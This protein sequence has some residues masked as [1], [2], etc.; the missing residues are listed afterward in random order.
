MMCSSSPLLHLPTELIRLISTSTDADTF[1][2]LMLTCR[3]VHNSSSALIAQHNKYRRLFRN[4]LICAPWEDCSR[5]VQDLADYAL[6]IAAHPEIAQYVHSL[7]VD[8]NREPEDLDEPDPAFEDEGLAWIRAQAKGRTRADGARLVADLELASPWFQAAAA[9]SEARIEDVPQFRKLYYGGD[10][11]DDDDDDDD[12]ETPIPE[13]EEEDAE[14]IIHHLLVLLLSRL[15][16]IAILTVG[17]SNIELMAVPYRDTTNRDSH[18]VLQ[19]MTTRINDEEGYQ[20]KRDHAEHPVCQLEDKG[21]ACP[22]SEKDKARL[23]ACSHLVSPLNN[24]REVRLD[25]EHSTECMADAQVL[26][27]AWASPRVKSMFASCLVASGE[28]DGDPAPLASVVWRETHPYSGIERLELAA[29]AI[30]P[31]AIGQLLSRM[32]FLKTLRYS[33]MVKEVLIGHDWDVDGFLKTVARAC[34]RVPALVPED[35]PGKQVDSDGVLSSRSNSQTQ[36]LG[37]Q[38][39]DLGIAVDHMSNTYPTGV[40]S[41]HEFTAL[42]RLEVDADI[43]FGPNP[44]SG[45]RRSGKSPSPPTQPGFEK[46][47]RTKDGHLP[48]LVDVLPPS[49]EELDLHVKGTFGMEWVNLLQGFGAERAFKLPLL[50]K[51]TVHGELVHVVGQ[52]LSD[53]AERERLATLAR[54]AIEEAGADHMGFT[55]NFQ[56]WQDEFDSRV[57]AH[58]TLVGSKKE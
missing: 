54:L 26:D 41:L 33:H 49:I 16:H 2:N 37:D 55:S 6:G 43:F 13:I 34:P 11:G 7:T 10:E 22:V 28:Y 15:N 46:W 19:L 27:A 57:S 9:R 52:Y 21:I 40:W 35:S 30:A 45:E 31:G 47:D 39:N 53:P 24:L 48:R 38:I 20:A 36:R 50:R 56:R 29:S 1:E 42:K 14:R 17:C 44:A 4:V 32:P 51:F 3:T 58:L 25:L 18:R 8:Y 23:R 12:E 5:L